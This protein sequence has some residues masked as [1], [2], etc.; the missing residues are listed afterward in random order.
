MLADLKFASRQLRK[1]PGF[2]LTAVMTLAI[3]IGGV[4][5]VFS[6]VEAVLLRPLPFANPD[7]LARI[8]EG[9]EHQ[10]DAADLPAP[11]VIQ[12]ARDNRTF[13]AVAGF[14][15]AEYE[16]SGAGSP[17]RARAERVN[18]SLFPLLGVQPLLGRTFTQSEDE[19][20]APVAVISYALWQERFQADTGVVGKTVD[21][22]RRPY[23]V[24]GVM[25]RSFE[26]PIEAGRLKPG[27]TLAQARADVHRMIA[28]IEAQIP[29]KFGIHL[30]SDV[31]SFQE[32]TVS[33]ARPLLRILMGATVLILCIAC[34]NLA[35][36]LLVRGAG[37]R[38][39]F[40][41]RLALG[42]G[43]RAMLRQSLTESLLLSVIG[44][45]F[46]IVLAA[47]LV[48]IAVA[49][50]PGSMPRLDE[51]ALRWPMLL[52]AVGLAALTGLLCGLAPALGSMR[53]DILDA[54]R[55]GSQGTGQSRSQHRFRNI[56][57]AV[58]VALATVLLVGA[59]LFL[60]S[61][62]KML[63]TDPGFQPQ[64]VLTA[65]LSLPNAEYSTQAG[66]DSFY[67]ELLRRLAALPGVSATGASSAVPA[68]GITS[69]RNF[70]PEGYAPHS[71]RLWASASNS[72]IMGDYFR[73]MRIPLLRGRYLNTD[74]DAPDAPLA[75]VI[76]ETLAKRYWSG[77]NPVG[78]R[79]RM[80]GDPESTRPY[81]TVVGVVGDIRQGALDQAIYPQM[82]EPVSQAARQFEP[83]VAKFIGA[84]GSFYIAVRSTGAAEGLTTSVEK[85][86]H[87]LDPRLA[88]SQIHTMT[89]RIAAAEAPRRF[90]TAALTAFAAIALLL[91]LLGIYG[92]LAYA[93][94]ERTR[95]IAIRMALGATRAN[96]LRQTLRSALSLAGAGIAAG[97]VASLGLTQF[98]ESML[99]GVK[100]L[101]TD[102]I[103]GAVTVLLACAALAGWLPARKAASVDPMDTLRG[104]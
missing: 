80:G 95:E 84:R 27:V 16:L 86:V 23:T 53:A 47:G 33:A 90:N 69:D 39:E 49:S 43:R 93:V 26:F 63:E 34:V 60:R 70:V 85:T 72:F 48:R 10:F 17:L 66:I 18:A 71:G 64:H 9:V 59:G 31:R 101:D 58:E 77:Q 24:I 42:A 20:S 21:L 3:G 35:N 15:S 73:A 44:S 75:A 81:L 1:S 22:D 45:I 92:V 29:Q 14:I 46:G 97:L 91:A 87:R 74:D 67:H 25:P 104:E 61:F 36:L 57:V 100:P 37:R 2:T 65:Y 98:L 19:H 38:R 50:M 89:D 88:I 5:A 68:A 28:S 62:Q 30:T 102:A 94:T 55:E 56:L 13:T 99:Y 76:S 8:H 32:E 79:F 96:V 11:D 54:L 103:I 6:L 52:F 41:V 51:V 83:K 78:R 82:Y 4:I 12:I 7:G 40:G